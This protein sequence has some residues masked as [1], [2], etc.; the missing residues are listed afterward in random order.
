MAYGL[1]SRLLMGS[2][3]TLTPGSG[4]LQSLLQPMSNGYQLPPGAQPSGDTYPDHPDY[5]ALGGGTLPGAKYPPAPSAAQPA[6]S[7]A[8]SDFLSPEIALPMAGALMAGPT[9]GEGMGNALSYGGRALGAKNSENKT[10]AYLAANFPDLSALAD[11]GAPTDVL[12]KAALLKKGIG[13]KGVTYSTPTLMAGKNGDEYVMFGS[14]GTM[15]PLANESGL[16]PGK[17]TYREG[18]TYTSVIQ[19]GVEIGRIPK[20]VYGAGYQHSLGTEDAKAR[21]DIVKAYRDMTSK[22]P[23][24]E[25]RVKELSGLADKATYTTAG[26]AVDWARAEVGMDPRDAA[27]ARTT[28][29]AKVA[30]QILPLLRG[31]FGA[32]FTEREGQTLMATLGDINKTPKE[33]QA[34]LEAFIVQKRQDIED[35][36]REAAAYGGG[37]DSPPADTQPAPTGGGGAGG[38]TSTGMPWSVEP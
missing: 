9:F 26:Q 12:W 29:E 2:P 14:D 30:N 25:D 34:A 32:Q 1:L 13:D 7:S 11:A 17:I 28:Y 21:A 27:V 23:G 24:L 20:D 3:Q 22:M 15:K 19:D 8:L 35:K 5:P 36:A 10:K 4:V 6:S 38:T 31:T 33:K 16:R 18:G 37:G